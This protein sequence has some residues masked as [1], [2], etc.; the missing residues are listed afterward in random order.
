[1]DV[2]ANVPL[3][4]QEWRSGVEPDANAHGTR[5]ETVDDRPRRLSRARR[6]REREEEGIA[7]RVDLDAAVLVTGSAHDLTMLGECDGI[8]VRSELVHELGRALDVG[9]EESDGARRELN[10]H[11]RI[12]SRSQGQLN[13]PRPSI[14]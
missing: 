1:M 11:R 9:E 13:R 2:R 8:P 7:L 10:A 5:A 12:M 3:V 6:S 4:G 14:D